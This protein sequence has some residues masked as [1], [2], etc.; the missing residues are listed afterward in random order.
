MLVLQRIDLFP[1]QQLCF[2]WPTT[3][4][5]RTAVIICHRLFASIKRNTLPTA[6]TTSAKTSR[7]GRII[8]SW[9][10]IVTSA[11][12]ATIRNLAPLWLRCRLIT[13][14]LRAGWCSGCLGGRGI[15]VR[16]AAIWA[17]WWGWWSF[18]GWMTWVINIWLVSTRRYQTSTGCSLPLLADACTLIALCIRP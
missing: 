17:K 11:F 1:V 3:T 5:T 6:N 4:A 15:W 12:T 16:L 7:S 18:C 9:S 14:R 10:S 8:W 13:G 2:W